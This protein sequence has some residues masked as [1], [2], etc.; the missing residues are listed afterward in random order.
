MWKISLPVVPAS[1]CAGVVIDMGVSVKRVSLGSRCAAT[2]HRGWLA[3]RLI[4]QSQASSIGAGDDGVLRQYIVLSEEEVVEI[5]A[6][7]DFVAASTLPCAALTAWNALFCGSR[8]CRPG[9]NVLVQGS[10]G[11]SLFACQFARAAGATVIATTG[12]LGGEREQ[13]LK[14]LGASFV[15]SYREADW[16]SQVKSLTG[17]HSADIIVEVSGSGEQDAK[18]LSLNGQIAVI[19][20]LGAGGSSTFDMRVT[21]GELRRIMV[22]SREQFEDMN[23]AIEAQGIRP[24]VD[25]KTWTFDEVREAYKHAATGKMWGRLSSTLQ[26]TELRMATACNSVESRFED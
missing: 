25:S 5:P 11:V 13:K 16:S 24:V 23:R 4:S 12:E 17:G 3:G 26:R 18:A 1:D 19:G 2:F 22:G 8:S 20:G 6:S 14:E 10:G 9:D 21:L 15:V 7:L